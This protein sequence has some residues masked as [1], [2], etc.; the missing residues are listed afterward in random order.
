M[1]KVAALAEANGALVSPHSACY[2]PG[3]L[4]TVHA[5]AAMPNETVLERMQVGLEASLFPEWTTASK[6][7]VPVP[8]GPGLGADP[9]PDVIERYRRDART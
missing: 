6:G 1:R 4:A 8:T 9:D 2:G 7:R 3:F 5:V